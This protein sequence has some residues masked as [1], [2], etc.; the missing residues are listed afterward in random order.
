[1]GKWAAR[2]PRWELGIRFDL[3]EKTAEDAESAKI[4]QR[5]ILINP[6][7]PRL[8]SEDSDFDVKFF[9]RTG[10]RWGNKDHNHSIPGRRIEW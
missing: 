3:T 4:Y 1:M 6:R 5:K 8:F 7:N 10:L 2:L 9:L